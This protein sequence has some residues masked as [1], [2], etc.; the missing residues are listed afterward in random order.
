[1]SQYK[2]GFI[3]FEVD[4]TESGLTQLA[5]VLEVAKIL[6]ELKQEVLSAIAQPSSMI[7]FIQKDVLV[8]KGDLP[9]DKTNN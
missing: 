1:M 5:A 6:D 2:I 9:F 4:F 3:T 7:V 8:D